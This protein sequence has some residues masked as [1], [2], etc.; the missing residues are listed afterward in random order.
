V[1]QYIYLDAFPSIAEVEL[2]AGI[3]RQNALRA[4]V[5]QGAEMQGEAAAV[6]LPT[7]IERK[8]P[9]EPGCSAC[10]CRG[11]GGH[12]MRHNVVC[13]RKFREWWDAQDAPGVLESAEVGLSTDVDDDDRPLQQAARQGE[14]AAVRVPIWKVRKRCL[15][16]G[17]TACTCHGQGCQRR[18][19]NVAVDSD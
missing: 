3:A 11:Q 15:E 10:K 17:C 9:L 4:L 13:E 1:P 8:R 7:W 2:S 6:R 12:G 5:L 18:R 16:L 19:H 14:A